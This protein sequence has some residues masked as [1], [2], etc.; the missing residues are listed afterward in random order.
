M[1]AGSVPVSASAC[2]K[3]SPRAN[4]GGSTRPCG[5]HC[6]PAC[7]ATSCT[8][9]RGAISTSTARPQCCGHC[10]NGDTRAA[11]LSPTVIELLRALPRASEHVFP[12]GLDA[13]WRT[14][15][16]R[17]GVTGFRWHDMR[18]DVGTRLTGAG[19][20]TRV[21]MLRGDPS[22]RVVVLLLLPLLLVRLSLKSRVPLCRAALKERNPKRAARQ[23][24]P[25]RSRVS[26]R[27]PSAGSHCGTSPRSRSGLTR[28]RSDPHDR[29]VTRRTDVA[30]VI[31]TTYGKP[32]ARVWCSP[33]TGRTHRRSNAGTASGASAIRKRFAL[34][35]DDSSLQPQAAN[36]CSN[37]S[38]KL[39]HDRC[40]AR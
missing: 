16:A 31:G 6:R 30:R 14:A 19:V 35:F 27:K 38:L 3:R 34:Q 7:A 21:V 20:S 32:L 25:K 15:L 28:R 40:F 1:C 29:S 33:P 2:S 39:R 12:Q 18:H 9:S 17:S 11:A 5:S 10:K 26:R 37:A 22:P 8:R 23:H 24:Q 36:H 13:A 4:H